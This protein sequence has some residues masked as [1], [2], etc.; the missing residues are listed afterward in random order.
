M[1]ARKIIMKTLFVQLCL[2]VLF[3]PSAFAQQVITSIKTPLERYSISPYLQDNY[4][5]LQG[6]TLPD[7]VRLD[8][9]LGFKY[10]SQPWRL[11][12]EISN[13]TPN[14]IET[15]IQ[16][17]LQFRPAIL[18]GY[19]Q[20]FDMA[21][22]I[23]FVYQT[24]G[25][26][27]QFVSVSGHD[28]MHLLDPELFFRIPFFHER[29]KGFGLAFVSQLFFPASSDSSQ[30]FVGLNSFQALLLAVVDWRW[31]NLGVNLNT[32]FLLRDEFQSAD[33]T[34]GN[35]LI[36]RPGIS[37]SF[38]MGSYNFG[39][40]IEA[41]VA[42]GLGSSFAEYNS[43]AYQLLFSI[44]LQPN[45]DAAQVF[46]A[47]GGGAKLQGGGY[48]VPVAN[49]DSRFG[50]SFTLTGPKKKHSSDGQGWATSSSSKPS[51]TPSM[52]LDD[53]ENPE[54]AS[55]KVVLPQDASDSDSAIMASAERK[56]PTNQG[57]DF[58]IPI[59]ATAPFKRPGGIA[60]IR[61][62]F[63]GTKP[64]E[65]ETY[66]TVTNP[67]LEQIATQKGNIINKL[68]Q[69]G[70]QILV[71][72]FTDKCF[73]GPVPLGN[74]YNRKLSMRRIE[75]M[76]SMFR[77]VLGEAMTGVEIKKIAQGR[78]CANPD[79]KC[80]TPSMAACSKDRRVEVYIEPRNS[81]EYSCPNGNYWLC[82]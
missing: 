47:M 15:P 4:I 41:N 27:G 64:P 65:T 32:G 5:F 51:K 33:T 21:L 9:S 76:I 67:T 6:A 39:I 60:E 16:D 25:A 36:V 13:S 62:A 78:K 7:I 59:G 23:P 42:T 12:V 30:S 77:Q 28:G 68:R 3:A 71:V 44:Q 31:E 70:A 14:V 2:I 79:C 74:E 11:F 82:P 61:F 58:P 50:Y 49:V 57:S 72:G 8:L 20:Y 40:A 81:D 19:R 34:I 43:G 53:K 10:M 69:P 37:Y 24:K 52:P 29:K 54:E 66:P 75:V 26:Y 48:G 55:G 35:E 45:P 18:F 56:F 17:H 22:V 1:S 38:P 73:S 63:D 46:L 80:S